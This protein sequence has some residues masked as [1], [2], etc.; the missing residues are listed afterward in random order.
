MIQYE[1]QEMEAVYFVYIVGRGRR[2]S[3]LAVYAQCDDALQQ[4]HTKAAPFAAGHRFSYCV[5]H[6]IRID[7][8]WRS[9]GCNIAKSERGG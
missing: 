2:L 1:V 8:H 4:R 6:S 5:D 3:V 9:Y 7:G